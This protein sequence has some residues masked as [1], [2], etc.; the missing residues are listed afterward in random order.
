MK[1]IIQT[2]F[3]AIALAAVLTSL[4]SCNKQS[5][6]INNSNNNTNQYYVKFKVDG[7]EIKYD[8]TGST[9]NSVNSNGEY[10][11]AI[12]GQKSEFEYNKNGLAYV[13]STISPATINTTYTNYQ[14]SVPGYV[15]APAYVM[16][17]YDNN[18]N[19]FGAWGDLFASAGVTSDAKVKLTAITSTSLRGTFS[20][21]VYKEINGA[22]A[23]HLIT[24]GEFFVRR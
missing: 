16:G 2:T 5:D 14:S 18:G 15:K 11:T 23:K 19:F 7:T 22:S 4:Y 21:T 20:A 10:G 17:W 1:K 13:I 3:L 6:I 9:L 24:D 8:Y 12:S